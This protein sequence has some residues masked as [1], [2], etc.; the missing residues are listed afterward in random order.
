MGCF[1]TGSCPR[2]LV[3]CMGWIHGMNSDFACFADIARKEVT[4]LLF[5][6][7]LN[8]S[9]PVK[10][11]CYFGTSFFGSRSSLVLKP[12]QFQTKEQPKTS[13]GAMSVKNGTTI[14]EWHTA[15]EPLV[16]CT[17]SLA[18][19]AQHFSKCLRICYG[20]MMSALTTEGLIAPLDSYALLSTVASV[21]S[22]DGAVTRSLRSTATN[23]QLAE[24]EIWIPLHHIVARLQNQGTGDQ[25][26]TQFWEI[27]RLNTT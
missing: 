10:K 9:A 27:W 17:S 18:L 20:T 25:M 19:Q 13:N 24:T 8:N 23:L 26:P 14:C 15:H 21:G 6:F 1:C 11:W 7:D 4:S 5:S 22:E 16:H 3:G 12:D 2:I